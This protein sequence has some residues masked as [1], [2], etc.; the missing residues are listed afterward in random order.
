M[1]AALAVVPRLALLRRQPASGGEVWRAP[2]LHGPVGAADACPA[3]LRPIP[4]LPVRRL[5]PV[6]DSG[7]AAAHRYLPL[8]TE[9]HRSVRNGRGGRRR[10]SP[11]AGRAADRGWIRPATGFAMAAVAGSLPLSRLG[12]DGSRLELS[13]SK[14]WLLSQSMVPSSRSSTGNSSSALCRASVVSSFQESRSAAR[15]AT[16][17]RRARCGPCGA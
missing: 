1:M 8:T 9:W 14:M 10:R 2:G 13:Q 7:A 17:S 15:M 12:L 16:T 4:D 3:T 5:Q 11:I 6:L